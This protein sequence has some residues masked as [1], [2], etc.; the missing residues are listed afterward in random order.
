MWRSLICCWAWLLLTTSIWADEPAEPK[1]SSATPAE[2]Y[3]AIEAEFNAAQQEFV[4][5]YRE[6]KTNEERQKVAQEKSPSPLAYA[7]RMFDLAKNHPDDPAA[8]DALTWVVMRAHGPVTDRAVEALGDHL[9]S[10]RLS[11][12]C[13]R[14]GAMG[15]TPRNERFLRQVLEKNKSHEVQ[16]YACLSLAQ[17]LKRQA[18]R[19]NANEIPAEKMLKEAEQLF[20]RVVNDFGDVKT[21]RGTPAEGAESE[22]FELRNLAVGKVAPEIEGEDLD[23]QPFKLSDYRGKVVM[24]DFWGNW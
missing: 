5:L 24:L 18:E 8:V 21:L 11:G 9:D 17:A 7:D 6:A 2:Q 12:V 13:Q 20:E 15:L 4:K 23:G 22:L 10:D 14:L 19:G 16:A 3:K 1:P